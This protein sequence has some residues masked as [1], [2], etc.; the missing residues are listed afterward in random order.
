MPPAFEHSSF[1][2]HAAAR[3]NFSFSWVRV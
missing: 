1:A 2:Y 3:E